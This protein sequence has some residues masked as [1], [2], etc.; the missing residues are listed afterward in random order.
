MLKKLAVAFVVLVVVIGFGVNYLWSNLDSIVKSTIVK[1]GTEA[2][3]T[4]V[5]VSSVH[6]SI[7]TGEGSLSGLSVG[8]PKGFSSGKALQMGA[9][10]LKI[11]TNS[12]MGNGPIIIKE[13]TIEKPEINYDVTT[14]GDSNLQAIQRNAASYAAGPAGN[15][16]TTGKGTPGRKVIINDLYIRNTQMD[17]SSEMLKGQK[18]SAVLPLIHLSGIGKD[19]GGATPADVAKQVLNAITANASQIANANLAKQLKGAVQ[20]NLNKAIGGGTLP[21]K[22]ALKGMFR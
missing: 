9:I 18:L 4:D 22:D 5:G 7:T 2:T 11:D 1:Y 3:Q 20:E 13:I 14:T 8:N 12:V 6:L 10:D 17:I 15:S 16:T 19:K 21:N